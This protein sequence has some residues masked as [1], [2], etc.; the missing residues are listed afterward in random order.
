MNY[1]VLDLEW[2]QSP[3]G[4]SGEQKSLPFEIIEIGAIKLNEKLEY[5]DQYQGIVRPQVYKEMNFETQKIVQVDLSEYSRIGRI[6]SAVAKEFL[7]WCGE[8]YIFCTW[9]TLD[10]ME[11][12]RNMKYYGISY[13]LPGP[14]KYYDIQKLFSFGYEDRKI[15]RTLEYVVQYFQIEEEE[16][17]HLAIHDAAYTAKVMQNMDMKRL[18]IYYSIDTYENPKTREEE[19]YAKYDN[20]SKYI[21]REFPTKEEAMKD[22]EVYSCK[23]C[24]CGKNTRR[25]IRWFSSG[26]NHYLCLSS[27]FRHGYVRGKM[28]FKKT[29]EDNYYVIK[30]IKKI[31]KEAAFKVK[32]RQDE[33]REKRKQKRRENRKKT[34]INSPILERNMG[35]KNL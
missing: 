6:F 2:N 27:C 12:Q 33:I 29:E 3:F 25:K 16:P 26:T 23:C 15:R 4:K 31:D 20:Y 30:I 35:I 18:W 13:L 11:L 14:L 21:S 5:V 34:E 7:K 8:D 17:Y 10:V 1:I 32:E 22:K 28:K 24:I 19:I 9:G